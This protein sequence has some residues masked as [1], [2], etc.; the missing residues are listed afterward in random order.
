MKDNKN[1]DFNEFTLE[2]AYLQRVL[3]ILY[4]ALIELKNIGK[5]DLEVCEVMLKIKHTTYYRFENLKLNLICFVGRDLITGEIIYLC[6]DNSRIKWAIMEGFTDF[7]TMQ[8]I[9]DKIGV[10]RRFATLNDMVKFLTNKQGY[11]F[12]GSY[13]VEE[14]KS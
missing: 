3:T 14:G 6:Q 12:A 7:Y 1:I 9:W 5:Q 10:L 8:Q 2:D 4:Y 13:I 11:N